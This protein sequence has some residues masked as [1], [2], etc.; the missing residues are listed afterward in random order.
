MGVGIVKFEALGKVTCRLGCPPTLVNAA[1]S[2]ATAGIRD[3]G[4]TVNHVFQMDSVLA[5]W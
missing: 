2:L 3:A 4:K 1:A 5:G